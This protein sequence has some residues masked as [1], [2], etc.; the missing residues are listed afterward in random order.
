MLLYLDSQRL[1]S[2]VVLCNCCFE[3]QFQRILEVKFIEGKTLILYSSTYDAI[4]EKYCK[5][6]IYL[7]QNKLW[8]KT[9]AKLLEHK[10]MIFV[11]VY[12]QQSKFVRSCNSKDSKVILTLFSSQPV[13]TVYCRRDT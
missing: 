13:V 3:E 10:S 1:H 9:T 4:K 2:V 5:S 7:T 12:R 8:K 6:P 11:C